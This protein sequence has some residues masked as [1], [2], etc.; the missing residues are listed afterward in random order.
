MPRQFSREF[1]EKAVRR[2]QAGEKVQALATELDVWPKLL[3]AWRNSFEAGG[4]DALLPPGRPGKRAATAAVKRLQPAAGAAERRGEPPTAGDRVAEL[5]RKVGQ[6]ALELDFFARALRHIK[7]S[8]RPS[9]G[10][11]AAASST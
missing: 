6:Q 3:Y 4:P 8:P 9:T 10:R 2:M 5:E 11:G 1:K 7:G